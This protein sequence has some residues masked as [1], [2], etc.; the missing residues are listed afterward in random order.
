MVLRVKQYGEAVLRKKGKKV[1]RFDDALRQL[2]AD[3]LES[4]HDNEGIG[5]AAQQ[6]GRALQ[7]CVIDFPKRDPELSFS[8]SIDGRQPP[9]ELLLPL[10][11]V[12]PR[13]E[14]TPQPKTIYEE[15]CLS[16]PGIRAEI[17][18]PKSIVAE[19]QDVQGAS[20]TLSC[21]GFLAR[22]ILHEV[23]H[24]NGILFIKRMDPETLKSLEPSLE[25]LKRRTRRWLKKQKNKTVV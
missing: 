6:I 22:V 17:S 23:D 2:A 9:I 25:K 16:F 4:M 5:L 13:L 14:V 18:R 21:D 7:I 20:H 24:L 1:E 12:N 3:M 11:L 15:G 19:F 10:T 8:Y